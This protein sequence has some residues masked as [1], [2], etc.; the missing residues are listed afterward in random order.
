VSSEIFGTVRYMKKWIIFS[1]LLCL[2]L[3]IGSVSA[4]TI[5]ISG[6]IVDDQT[7]ASMAHPVTQIN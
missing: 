5:S 3:L 2:L 7:Y 1:G 6:V 4:E